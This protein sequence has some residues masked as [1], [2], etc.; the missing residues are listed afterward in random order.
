[1]NVTGTSGNAVFCMLKETVDKSLKW[2]P[3]SFLA[4]PAGCLIGVQSETLTGS[5]DTHSEQLGNNQENH[6]V[7]ERQ[8]QG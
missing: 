6:T 1:M 5:I 7:Y 4:F 8:N 2:T 3:G